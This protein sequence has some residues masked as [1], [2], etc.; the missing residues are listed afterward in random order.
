MRA[1]A[2]RPE[3][4]VDLAAAMTRLADAGAPAPR[5]DLRALA[6]ENAVLARELAR[7]QA[8]CTRWRDDCIARA[9]RLE[10]QL[11]QTRAEAIARLTRIAALED[12][13]RTAA[14]GGR[15]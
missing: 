13:L 11:M 14:S 6:E 7:V 9:E 15:S 2:P 5:N 3:H 12:L 4:G 1:L 10:A 8:H